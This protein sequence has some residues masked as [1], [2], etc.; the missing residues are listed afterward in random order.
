MI[1]TRRI[2]L[3]YSLLLVALTWA[4]AQQP[5]ALTQYTIGIV[6][7]TNSISSMN[8]VVNLAIGSSAAALAAAGASLT[9][10][11]LPVPATP[12]YPL[13]YQQILATSVSAVSQNMIGIVN[14][15]DSSAVQG[16]LENTTVCNR[17][18]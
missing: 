5:T 7:T 8:S 6:G 1:T 17:S 10:V 13:E 14:L 4:S 2:G 16:V 18:H 12:A 3:L 9:A 11:A 15:V